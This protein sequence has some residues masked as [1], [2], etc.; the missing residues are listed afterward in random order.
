[1]RRGTPF[2]LLLVM[3]H[4]LRIFFA[5]FFLGVC[6]VCSSMSFLPGDTLLMGKRMKD[7]VNAYVDSCYGSRTTI[8]SDGTKRQSSNE[9]R[10]VHAQVRLRALRHF[11]T[12]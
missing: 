4:R 2:L 5:L 7:D 12:D 10:A 6:R 3:G 8:R 1:M 9:W 11:S